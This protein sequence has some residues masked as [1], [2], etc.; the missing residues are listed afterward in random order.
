MNRADHVAL[1]TVTQGAPA[2]VMQPLHD[3]I[4][5]SLGPRAGERRGLVADRIRVYVLNNA[6][7]LAKR[8]AEFMRPL[9]IEPRRVSPKLLLAAIEHGSLEDDPE[10]QDRWAALIAAAAA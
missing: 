3:L 8:A 9:G 10:I 1:R 6:A 2:G 7:R 4:R 5:A